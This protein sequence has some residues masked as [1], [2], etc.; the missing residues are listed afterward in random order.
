MEKQQQDQV[1]HN[2][3]E[4]HEKLEIEMEAASHEHK[5]MLMKQ[6]LRRHQE[7]LWRMEE[8]HNQEVQK[9]QLELR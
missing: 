5:V 6:G 7:E 3:K 1:D 9:Q 8:L 2:I 4:A